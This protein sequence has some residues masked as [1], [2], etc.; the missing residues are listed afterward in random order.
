DANRDDVPLVMT[1]AQRPTQRLS[2]SNLAAVGAAVTAQL[3]TVNGAAVHVPKA[4]TQQLWE[5]LAAGT[6]GARNSARA[7][8][9]PGLGDSVAKVWL[10]RVFQPTLDRSVP[11][12]GAPIAWAAGFTGRGVLVAVIDS[13]VDATHPDLADRVVD[14]RNFT[15]EVDDDIVGHGT[16]VASIIA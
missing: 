14:K 4:Q 3:S 8:A 1:Y 12:I 11:E 7:V 6:P 15:D 16:H 5:S 10:D 2:A 9:V 13:G